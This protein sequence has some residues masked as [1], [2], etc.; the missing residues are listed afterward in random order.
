MVWRSDNA[1]RAALF[2]AV[3]LLVHPIWTGVSARLPLEEFKAWQ[4][5]YSRSVME[6]LVQ[7]TLGC[8]PQENKCKWVCP[9]CRAEKYNAGDHYNE[10]LQYI[11]DEPIRS[12]LFEA[13][14]L[15]AIA[16]KRYN[17]ER[18]HCTCFAVGSMLHH[19]REASFPAFVWGA[20]LQ[21]D[22]P[23]LSSVVQEHTH[24]L[25]T[26]GPITLQVLRKMG[27]REL[28][29]STVVFGDPGLLV[30]AV[31]YH[32]LQYNATY[33]TKECLVPH[34]N[35]EEHSCPKGVTT[36][37]PWMLSEAAEWECFGPDLEFM[38]FVRRI[39]Q[40]GRITTSS[41]HAA[42]F[43]DV[44]D[45]PVR[46]KPVHRNTVGR[47]FKDYLLVVRPAIAEVLDEHL[48]RNFETAVKAEALPQV[49]RQLI[50]S[51]SVGLVHK[52]AE[53]CSI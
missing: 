43:A 19:L 9:M 1:R 18:S 23:R 50:T 35:D 44:F 41:L 24:V 37:A 11:I 20:G 49:D 7:R 33:G 17:L 28:D 12:Q 21:G 30:G 39:L 47:K 22:M 32:H 5:E 31:L 34:I 36:V 26:R 38:D 16:T 46:I 27:V 6:R 8:L 14:E 4:R 42:V 15:G 13:A 3:A 53:A 29:N 2:W 51:L 45:V 10:Y 52:L 48:H 25:A 40:C